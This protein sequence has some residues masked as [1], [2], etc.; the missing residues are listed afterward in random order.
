[1]APIWGERVW[2]GLTQSKRLDR[3][4]LWVHAVALGLGI[5]V[6]ACVRVTML[7]I[8]ACLCDEQELALT[9]LSL[10]QAL[11]QHLT[12]ITS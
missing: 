1:M 2:P 5:C 8:C 9:G 12:G 7:V 4:A 6:F 11:C 10:C 3:V